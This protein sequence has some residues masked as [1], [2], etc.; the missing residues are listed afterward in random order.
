MNRISVKDQQPKENTLVH[1]FF[2]KYRVVEPLKRIGNFWFCPNGV[3][4]IWNSPTH[5]MPISSTPE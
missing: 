5:W 3:L 4:Y 1:A 2:G